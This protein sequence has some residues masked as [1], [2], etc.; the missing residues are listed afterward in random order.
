MGLDGKIEEQLFQKYDL[1]INPAE[2][3]STQSI[4]D[5]LPTKRRKQFSSKLVTLIEKLAPVAL[6]L[7]EPVAYFRIERLKR[8]QSGTIYV[9][10]S[11]TPA[12]AYRSGIA[13]FRTVKSL[14]CG[15]ESQKESSEI[16]LNVRRIQFAFRS[17][18]VVVPFICTI[19][20]RIDEKMN[21]L[22]ETRDPLRNWLF[23]S[24]CSYLTE[25]FA[26]HLQRY[27]S[28]HFSALN[29]TYRFSPGYCDWDIREQ[30]KIFS[31][32]THIQKAVTLS[33]S[34]IMTPVKSISGIFGLSGKSAEETNPCTICPKIDCSERR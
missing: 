27:V 19:G 11:E 18:N 16:A 22:Y 9:S 14:E 7:A 29:A 23:D 12:Y 6:D 26:D 21:Q 34:C 17:S 30:K 1:S 8:R 3:L 10:C 13:E 31:F 5:E 4:L 20:A 28:G 15:F 33:D 2:F 32:F 25:K 24:L